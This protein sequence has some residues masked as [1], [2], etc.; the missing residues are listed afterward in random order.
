MEQNRSSSAVAVAAVLALVAVEVSAVL[1]D[2]D[3]DQNRLA[4]DLFL[5]AYPRN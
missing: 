2:V 4:E 5:R 1:A 3:L